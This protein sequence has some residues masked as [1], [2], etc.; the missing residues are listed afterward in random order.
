MLMQP[1]FL[2][3]YAFFTI[4]D[5]VRDLELTLYGFVCITIAT[6]LTIWILSPQED[7]DKIDMNKI[8]EKQKLKY[9]KLKI[10]T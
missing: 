2:V 1:I 7:D 4:V 8:Y 9:K 6:I 10:K 5:F 3:F